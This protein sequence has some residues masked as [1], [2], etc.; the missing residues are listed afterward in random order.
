MAEV[1]NGHQDEEQPEVAQE[2]R[3]SLEEIAVFILLKISIPLLFLILLWFL[4]AEISRSS[5]IEV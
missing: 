3:W 5:L 2:S 4:I 1:V